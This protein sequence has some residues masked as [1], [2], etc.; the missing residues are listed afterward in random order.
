VLP[1]DVWMISL[2]SESAVQ[3]VYVCH[4]SVCELS[5]AR[6][7]ARAGGGKAGRAHARGEEAVH[8]VVR[9]RR[10]ADEEE[11]L[12]PALDRADD[13]LEVDE[14][15]E[16]ARDGRAEDVARDEED[17]ER[18]GERGAVGDDEPGHGA[19]GVA[20][21][22]LSG[23]AAAGVRGGLTGEHDQR[24]VERDGGCAERPLACVE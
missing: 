10:E 14:L 22:R 19:E 12:R 21:A 24:R 20:W 13:A 2:K 9:V 18:A 8:D 3:S 1:I 4:V 23:S 6:E 5:A 15:G 11:Q 7:H 17:G 16:P